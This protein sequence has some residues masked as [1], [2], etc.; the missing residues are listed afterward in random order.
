[1]IK[2][3]YIKRIGPKKF[4]VYSEKGKNMGTYT[5]M[6]AAKNRLKQIEFF[7]HQNSADDNHLFPRGGEGS[8]P[9]FFRKNF[10]YGERDSQLKSRLKKLKAAENCLS[11]SG[12]KKEASQISS[13]AKNLWSKAIVIFAGFGLAVS[14]MNSSLEDGFLKEVSEEVLTEEGINPGLLQ[15]KV[16]MSGTPLAQLIQESYPGENFSGRENIVRELIEASND[17]ITID[18]NGNILIKEE[19]KN[20]YENRVRIYLPDIIKIKQALGRI[21]STGYNPDETAKME[22][23]S[24]SEEVIS[25]IS[26]SEGFRSKVYSDIPGLKWPKDKHKSAGIGHWTIGFGHL[27]RESELNSGNIELS[28]GKKIPFLNGIS[29]EEAEEIRLDD[30]KINSMSTSESQKNIQRSTYDAILDLAYNIG[31]PNAKRFLS[32][33]TDEKGNIS[34]DRFREEI[35]NWKGVKDESQ[36]KGILMRRISQQLIG[37]GVFLPENSEQGISG[38]Y[39]PNSLKFPDPKL[40]SGYISAVMERNP[41]TEELDL[42][43]R[44]GSDLKN[45]LRYH[46]D[47]IAIIK[48]VKEI[49]D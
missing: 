10:D 28:S 4:R 34:R 16:V 37:S 7:K 11:S 26:K 6:S 30:L 32:K 8:V 15:E 23:F 9:T 38:L 29:K 41:S 12:L 3:A 13:L 46:D 39:D 35:Y 36:R 5:S 49:N 18:L 45:P 33:I 22:E 17:H 14:A 2:Y 31:E 42:I 40:V 44:E 19:N 47:F 20:F 24:P 1:M 48:K 43:L 27:L 21:L 25:T